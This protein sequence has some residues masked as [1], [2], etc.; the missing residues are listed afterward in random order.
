MASSLGHVLWCGA[1]E[2]IRTLCLN[3]DWRKTKVVLV[4]VVSWD[5]YTHY[6]VYESRNQ[7]AAAAEANL[8][9]TDK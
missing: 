5:E 9:S 8:I 1:C 7:L 4:K 2:D 6:I 3:D